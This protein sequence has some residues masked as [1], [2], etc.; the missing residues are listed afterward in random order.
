[1]LRFAIVLG[2]AVL[3]F[4][5][6]RAVP[7]TYGFIG[8]LIEINGP[9]GSF[10]YALGEQLT[11]TYTLQTEYPDADPS[12]SRGDYSNPTGIPGIGPVLGVDIGGTGGFGS[13]QYIEVFNDY[14]NGGATYDGLIVTVGEPND[15]WQSTFT[16]LTRDLSVLSSDAIPAA[17]DPARFET[18]QFLRFGAPPD[19][20][21]GTLD[22]LV[23]DI[24]EPGA[25]AVFGTAL[26]AL[27]V[28]TRWRRRK[29]EPPFIAD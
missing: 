3:G 1:M 22:G 20:V 16:L 2:L 11:L 29:P 15:D 5:P 28:L 9:D 27:V 24:P 18:T 7:V 10:P 25:L 19:Y 21:R 17:I 26:L 4:T 13:I 14:A 23:T 6:A 12:A 8:T